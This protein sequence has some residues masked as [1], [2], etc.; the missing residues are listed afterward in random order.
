M[1]LLSVFM[2]ERME[3]IKELMRVEAET[4]GDRLDEQIKQEPLILQMAYFS[5]KYDRFKKAIKLI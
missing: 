1:S 2:G 4:D 5:A 3:N